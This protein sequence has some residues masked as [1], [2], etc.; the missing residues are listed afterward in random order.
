MHLRQPTCAYTYKCVRISAY[1]CLFVCAVY[2]LIR[3]EHVSVYVCMN[4]CAFMYEF[5]SVYV[6]EFMQQ[7]V[8]MSVCQRESMFGCMKKDGWIWFCTLLWEKTDLLSSNKKHIQIY[9]GKFL[10]NSTG[11]LRPYC[12]CQ[13]VQRF[14]Q[15]C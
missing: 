4:V 11:W 10:T 2:V 3:C 6:F 14:F 13:G 7:C 12:R 9:I 15:Q 1:M 5:M 8:C